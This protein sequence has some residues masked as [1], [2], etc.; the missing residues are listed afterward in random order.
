MCHIIIIIKS[1][2]SRLYVVIIYHF[3]LHDVLSPMNEGL[4]QFIFFFAKHKFLIDVI[5]SSNKA[6]F[7]FIFDN[8]QTKQN[9]P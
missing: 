8:V 5:T 6:F 4:L 3:F 2:F 1:L 7:I 9:R